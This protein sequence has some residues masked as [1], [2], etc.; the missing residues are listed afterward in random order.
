MGPARFYRWSALDFGEPVVE[1]HDLVATA[2]E[3]VSAVTC[4][5][6]VDTLRRKIHS[7]AAVDAVA[8]VTTD[9]VEH[10]P[11]A[12][13]VVAAAAGAAGGIVQSPGSYFHALVAVAVALEDVPDATVSLAAL[14]DVGDAPKT[15]SR[16][17]V[18]STTDVEQNLAAI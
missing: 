6:A 8:G 11:D 13:E 12:R 5:A 17:L 4:D 1:E 14:A 10:V 16:A 18:E 3:L 2:A 7:I 9:V 15:H